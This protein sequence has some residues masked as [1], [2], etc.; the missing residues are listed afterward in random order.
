MTSSRALL[1]ERPETRLAAMVIGLLLVALALVEGVT[2]WQMIVTRA[3]RAQATAVAVGTLD[4][5][6]QQYKDE[7]WVRWVDAGG[8]PHT[9]G[10]STNDDVAPKPG[11]TFSVAYDP[12]HP[13]APAYLSGPATEVND[14]HIVLAPG[15]LYGVS[16]VAQFL[17]WCGRRARSRWTSRLPARP[18]TAVAYSANYPR[19][20]RA[21]DLFRLVGPSTWLRLSPPDGA[22][23]APGA[24]VWQRVMWNP[25]FEGASARGAVTVRGTP[26]VDHVVG[27][28][29]ADGTQ[30]VPIGPVRDRPRNR[31]LLTE[32]GAKPRQGNRPRPPLAR[33]ATVCL[34]APAAAL[35]GAVGGFLSHSSASSI[36]GGVFASLGCALAG[37][38]LVINGWALTGGAPRR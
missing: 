15:I 7:I 21:D 38:A 13:S 4:P 28:E 35:V 34:L 10:V 23:S 25:T 6:H 8:D 2:S 19:G 32:L 26:A 30:L 14:S 24:A 29:L 9:Q 18:M 22:S 20:N 27:V 36:L 5:S 33:N 11:T 16:L 12:R 3:A 17:C 37:A 1:P 31:L